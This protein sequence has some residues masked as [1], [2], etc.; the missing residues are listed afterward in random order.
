MAE[1]TQDSARGHSAVVITR[2]DLGRFMKWSRKRIRSGLSAT[3]QESAKFSKLASDAK[4]RFTSDLAAGVNSSNAI[5]QTTRCPSSPQ[6]KAIEGTRKNNKISRFIS[7]SLIPGPQ[8]RG[9]F[10]A[11][12]RRRTHT[13]KMRQRTPRLQDRARSSIHVRGRAD[14]LRQPGPLPCRVPGSPA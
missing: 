4:R 8:R 14:R 3:K 10:Y 11:G 1:I 12:V 2:V 7:K 9:L 13:A 6:P 5:W